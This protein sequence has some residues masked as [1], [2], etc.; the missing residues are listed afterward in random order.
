MASFVSKALRI[1]SVTICVL[2]AAYFIVFA[3]NQTSTASGKQQ[4]ELGSKTPVAQTSAPGAPH[5]S[6]V[7]ADL[8]EAAEALT[9]PVSGL[10][11][12][13]S[14]GD[15]GLRLL[16]ALLVYGFLL[17]YLARVLRVRA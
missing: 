4:E 14:W 17:G 11:S 16:F 10:A 6:S 9:A 13:G 12:Q 8:D 1:A 7:H 15:H 3:L 5:E 2:V